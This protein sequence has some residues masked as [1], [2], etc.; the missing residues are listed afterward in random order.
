M[1][2]SNPAMLLLALGVGLLAGGVFFAG[3][4]FTVRQLAVAKRPA[5]LML[6]SSLVRIAVVLGAFFLVGRGHLDRMLA[7]LLG[8]LLARFIV[9]RLTRSEPGKEAADASQP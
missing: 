4:W 3:L 8:F 7:C 9:I 2:T 6:V 1:I 5:A